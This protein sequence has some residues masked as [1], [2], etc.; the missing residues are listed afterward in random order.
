MSNVTLYEYMYK[1]QQPTATC[2]SEGKE[3][4]K[5]ADA[6]DNHQTKDYPKQHVHIVPEN[7]SATHDD[8]VFSSCFLSPLQISSPAGAK[9]IGYNRCSIVYAILFRLFYSCCTIMLYRVVKF[10]SCEILI[11]MYKFI[12]GR[13]EPS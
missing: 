11:T 5:H 3:E 2:M 6:H 1:R 10:A 13:I 8:I 7:S 12:H 9:H 4:G